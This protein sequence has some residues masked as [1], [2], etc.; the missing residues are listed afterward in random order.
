[1]L[2][3]AQI[4]KGVCVR[5]GNSILSVTVGSFDGIHIAHRALIERAEAV[6]V[7]ERGG[8]SL[9]P[10]YKRAMFVRNKPMFFYHFEKI[11]HLSP[12]E[13]VALLQAHFPKLERIVVGYDFRFGKDKAGTPETL[14]AHFSGK[15]DV[16]DEVKLEGVS[17]HSRTIRTLLQEGDIAFANRMLGRAYE[18]D[19]RVIRGQGIGAKKL[20]PTLNLDVQAYTLPMAG[21]YATHTIL[22]NERFPSVSFIGH[23]ITTDGSFA[24]ETHLLDT[25]LTKRYRHAAVTFEAYLRPNRKFES[26]DALKEAI[27]HDISQARRTLLSV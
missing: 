24:V 14:Q 19:G 16:V 6:A 11:R 2:Q 10:G 27:E 3:Y 17:V 13:F 4:I 7:I 18:I 22:E 25:T 15:V 12:A 26:I 20:V 5:Y 21:V 1:M 23:R 9:T 8:G